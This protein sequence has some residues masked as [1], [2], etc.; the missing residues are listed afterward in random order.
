MDE[1]VTLYYNE[2]ENLFSLSSSDGA[3]TIFQSHHRIGLENGKNEIN[4]GNFRIEI[5]TNFYPTNP[6]HEFIGANIYVNGFL[7]LPVSKACKEKG[8]LASNLKDEIFK[9]EF[10]RNPGKDCFYGKKPYTIV[11]RGEDKDWHSLLF[12][13][14]V[15]CNHYEQWV[16][17]ETQRLLKAILQRGKLACGQLSSAIIMLREYDQIAPAVIPVYR[18]FFD[19][20]CVH[21]MYDICVNTQKCS[22]EWQKE[23]KESWKHYGDAV[24]KYIKDYSLTY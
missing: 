15:I 24:W 16:V 10:K 7:L 21:I 18:T 2:H 17:D 5:Q 3:I 12:Q 13:I 8:G 1:N 4:V 11:Q 9:A 23:Q 14:C 22:D 6:T 20:H 19:K